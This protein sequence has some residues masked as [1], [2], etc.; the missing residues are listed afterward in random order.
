[1]GAL[2]RRSGGRKAASE[3]KGGRGGGGGGGINTRERPRRGAA[4]QTMSFCSTA[5]GSACD[6]PGPYRAKTW[7]FRATTQARERAGGDP[8]PQAV[9]ALAKWGGFLRSAHRGRLP[10]AA[11]DRSPSGLQARRT[12]QRGPAAASNGRRSPSFRRPLLGS[13][14]ARL[15]P[16]PRFRFRVC[17]PHTRLPARG[18]LRIHLRQLLTRTPAAHPLEAA[19]AAFCDLDTSIPVPATASSATHAY[20]HTPTHNLM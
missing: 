20:P 3:E 19:P 17:W 9:S 6:V 18:S 12:A 15:E 4:H 14:T 13:S 2:A 5:R 11:A 7:R 16:S 1:M 8:P 10:R